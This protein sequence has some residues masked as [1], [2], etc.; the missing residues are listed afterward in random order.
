MAGLPRYEGTPVPVADPKPVTE[1]YTEIV[2]FAPF[3]V[4]GTKVPKFSERDLLTK[5]A[6]ASAILKRYHYSAFSMFQFK[7]DLRLNEMATL[8]HYADALKLL[9]DLSGSREIE[10]ECKRLFDRSR[11]PEAEGIDK[12][13]NSRYR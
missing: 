1:E 11:D 13:L 10:E 4:V 9:G 8:Q 7:E 5:E 2:H 12:F 3:V 6:F